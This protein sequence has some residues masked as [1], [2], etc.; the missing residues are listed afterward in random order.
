MDGSPGQPK[1]GVA[2]A[3]TRAKD[4]RTGVLTGTPAGYDVV[5]NR[6]YEARSRSGLS[7]KHAAGELGI[8][9][10]FLGALERE[11]ANPSFGLVLRMCQL[12]DEPVEELFVY[13]ESW[14]GPKRVGSRS[15]VAAGKPV[16]GG[17][18]A[19]PGPESS[20][21]PPPRH[22]AA[23]A[24][25]PET[26]V[27]GDCRQVDSFDGL[28]PCGVTDDERAAVDR[29]VRE[30]RDGGFKEG[31]AYH[32]SRRAGLLFAFE[33]VSGL[34]STSS[35]RVARNPADDTPLVRAQPWPEAAAISTLSGTV[36]SSDGWRALS[37]ILRERAGHR[38]SLCRGRGYR[39]ATE[40]HAAF[41]F[42]AN[43]G[44]GSRSGVQKL[45]ALCVLCPAC[46]YLKRVPGTLT[47]E[48]FERSCRHLERTNRWRSPEASEH[49]KLCMQR[50]RFLSELEWTL[51][52]QS[53]LATI[54]LAVGAD[55]EL[56]REARHRLKRDVRG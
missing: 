37:G 34:A 49:L 46:R 55:H 40:C 2:P 1:Q 38:C 50:A 12:Y 44:C 14:V 19:G 27:F 18:G 9:D 13:K 15:G 23:P 16:R 56:A 7:R 31:Y 54:A 25:E 26:T 48:N 21:S 11:K 29:I 30:V 24:P 6:L 41:D 39:H 32:R 28:E 45:S 4:R 10:G 42:V 5:P 8:T 35:P 51:N 53:V 17:R 33:Q 52:A 43:E 3:D 36:L 22:A 47:E 20:A